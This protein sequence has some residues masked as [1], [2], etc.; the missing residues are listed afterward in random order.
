MFV[1]FGSNSTIIHSFSIQ[2]ETCKNCD[3]NVSHEIHCTSSYF[4]LFFIPMF[5]L[6]KES[7]AVCSYCKHKTSE[8][9]WSESLKSKLIHYKT[10]NVKT[11]FWNYI[12]AIILLVLALKMLIALATIMYFEYF[13]T[14]TSTEEDMEELY[15][16]QHQN[17]STVRELSDVEKAKLENASKPEETVIDSIKT[18][19]VK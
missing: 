11:P 18:F 10:K 19:F 2:G 1:I 15:F 8:E 12:G 6:R 17:V 13:Q 4:T 7:Q 5:A 9:R 16:E 14:S 3:Q